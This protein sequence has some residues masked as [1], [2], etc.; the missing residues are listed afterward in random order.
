MQ[1]RLQEELHLARCGLAALEQPPL[2]MLCF[3]SFLTCGLDARLADSSRWENCSTMGLQFSTLFPNENLHVEHYENIK[4]AIWRLSQQ[5]FGNVQAG[6]SEIGPALT[7][8]FVGTYI[9]GI[10]IT[11]DPYQRLVACGS[12]KRSVSQTNSIGLVK[13]DPYQ[14]WLKRFGLLQSQAPPARSLELAA[15]FV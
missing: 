14:F 15:D 5:Q 4:H 8:R 11:R 2:N 6:S 7:L 13:Q 10:S 9:I 3:P 12:S 1:R